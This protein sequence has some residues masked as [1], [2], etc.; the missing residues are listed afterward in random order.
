MSGDCGDAGSDE[1]GYRFE[2]T[3]FLDHQTDLLRIRYL[4]IQNGLGVVQDYEH[5]IG[6]EEGS[7]GCHI[8]G[9]FDSR[10]DHLG[11]SSEEM[12][13]RYG[14]LVAANESTILPKTCFDPIVM[15]DSERNRRFPDSPRTD[16]CDG[17]QVFSQSDD[18][19]D[20][21]IASETVPRGR[22][23]RFTSRDAMRSSD[24]G[25]YSIQYN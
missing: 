15:K 12:S 13:T 20:Q 4:G 8:L 25:L 24:C 11:E 1:E 23:R 19:L 22:G 5:L 6:R 21:L 18:L 17:F 9:V 2:L 7:E 3:Q 16:K 14:E 10:A